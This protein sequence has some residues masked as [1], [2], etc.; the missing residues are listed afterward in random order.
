MGY[1]VKHTRRFEKDFMSLDRSVRKRIVE[2]VDLLRER[3]YIGKPLR[4]PLHGKWS[5][6]V[7]KYR[8]VYEI[9]EE[10]RI[11]FLLT[12]GPRKRIYRRLLDSENLVN[13]TDTI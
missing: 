3:P 1:K 11:V 12:V 5:I 6:R 4:G 8:L 7:G 10:N 9:D 2:I 13:P